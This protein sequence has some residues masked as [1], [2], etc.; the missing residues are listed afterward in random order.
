MDILHKNNGKN[1]M[2]YVE[3]NGEVLAEMT[4]V[5]S[6]ADKLIIDHTG[7]SE[8][9]KGKGVGKML[10][11]S[12]VDMARDKHVKILPICPFAKSEFEKNPVYNDVLF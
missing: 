9:L 2:F 11:K 10:V 4:Y 12:A 5:W 6:G 8:V 7:V 3:E 1:G